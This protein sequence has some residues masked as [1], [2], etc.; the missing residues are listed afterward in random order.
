[1]LGTK[2]SSSVHE[3]RDVAPKKMML[4]VSFPLPDFSGLSAE[5]QYKRKDGKEEA[6]SS[7][8]Q[9]KKFKQDVS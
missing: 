5:R 1:V 9:E 6:S 2:I 8:V 7:D 3:V 4:C